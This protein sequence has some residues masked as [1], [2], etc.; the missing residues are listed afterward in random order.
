MDLGY[1][2]NIYKSAEQRDF[3]S[4][5]F[6]TNNKIMLSNYF[7]MRARDD[8]KNLLTSCFELI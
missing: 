4:F 8:V 3:I 5:L 2:E 6:T 1:L 7:I